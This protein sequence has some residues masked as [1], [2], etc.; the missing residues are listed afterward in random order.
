MLYIFWPTIFNLSRF[1][2]LLGSLA[3]ALLKRDFLVKWIST[4]FFF[5]FRTLFG[6]RRSHQNS[7]TCLC[8]VR[9]KLDFVLN[10][11]FGGATIPSI[12]RIM[13]QHLKFKPINTICIVKMCGLCKLLQCDIVFLCYQPSSNSGKA[14][15]FLTQKIHHFTH[16]SL[17]RSVCNFY[18][19][20]RDS[21]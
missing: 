17:R 7:L 1:L 15:R 4:N 9:V 19:E 16:L 6:K 11:N 21:L 20:F 13:Q 5:F 3:I 14:G 12:Q 18:R 2:A 8:F 10:S